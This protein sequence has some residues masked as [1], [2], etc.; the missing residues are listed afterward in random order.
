MFIGN[1]TI[2]NND[3]LFLTRSVLLFLHEVN[4]VTGKMIFH[5]VL[6]NKLVSWVNVGNNINAYTIRYTKTRERVNSLK[7]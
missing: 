5:N 6:N 2:H 3:F 4:L 1:P 7:T